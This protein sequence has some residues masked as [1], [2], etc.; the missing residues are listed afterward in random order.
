MNCSIYVCGISWIK[1]VNSICLRYTFLGYLE[2]HRNERA[3]CCIWDGCLLRPHNFTVLFKGKSLGSYPSHVEQ[4]SLVKNTVD[5]FIS[6]FRKWQHPHPNFCRNTVELLL[7]SYLLWD[8]LSI[9]SRRLINLI[10]AI[11]LSK[12]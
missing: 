3:F 10:K 2:T 4:N 11:N 9:Q 7:F 8:V 6:F 1:K 5:H 12:K